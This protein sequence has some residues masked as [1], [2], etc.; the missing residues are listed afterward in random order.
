MGNLLQYIKEAAEE[1]V[2]KEI[3]DKVVENPKTITMFDIEES[4][5]DCKKISRLTPEKF[6]KCFKDQSVIIYVPASGIYNIAQFKDDVKQKRLHLHFTDGSII[7]VTDISESKCSAYIAEITRS[8]SIKTTTQKSDFWNKNYE[9]EYL[10]T[11]IILDVFR[12]L[13]LAFLNKSH[14]HPKVFVVNSPSFKYEDG[15]FNAKT[16]FGELY[17][18]IAKRKVAR[19]KLIN[20]LKSFINDSKFKYYKDVHDLRKGSTWN[21]IVFNTNY[22]PVS[23]VGYDKAVFLSNNWE[24]TYPRYVSCGDF[25]DP[26]NFG[27]YMM[28]PNEIECW[29][30]HASKYDKLKKMIEDG[31]EA[32][33][34]VEK[35][36][37][38][39]IKRWI[40]KFVLGEPVEESPKEEEKKIEAAAKKDPDNSNSSEIGS[41]KMKLSKKAMAQAEEKVALWYENKRKVNIGACSD[42]KLQLYYQ[43]AMDNGYTSILPTMRAEAKIRGLDLKYEEKTNESIVDPTEVEEII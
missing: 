32:S 27:D 28:Y 3:E 1:S 24:L 40:K 29:K 5:I 37:D 33:K 31:Y 34:A 35:K 30:F 36:C 6:Y 43:I 2:V 17:N 22:G 42:K 11:N 10:D 26:R 39:I 13:G 41:E 4:S 15:D 8:P 20:D 23:L 9:K 38:E 21:Y 16:F 25:K 12:S 14:R 19:D 18:T 7:F